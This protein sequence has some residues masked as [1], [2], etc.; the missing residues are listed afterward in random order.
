MI[1]DAPERR[2]E[3]LQLLCWSNFPIQSADKTYSVINMIT[4]CRT[5]LYWDSTSSSSYKYP[6]RATEKG[7]QSQRAKSR[8]LGFLLFSSLGFLFFF[9]FYV[10]EGEGYVERDTDVC[11]SSLPLYQVIKVIFFFCSLFLCALF[12]FSFCFLFFFSFISVGCWWHASDFQ[13]ISITNLGGC[14]RYFMEMFSSSRRITSCLC[15]T[16]WYNANR[17]LRS[18]LWFMRSTPPKQGRKC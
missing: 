16:W 17:G 3:D 10:S 5:E 8:V 11:F 2:L 18:I 4:S 6:C 13:R 15:E 12:Y 9:N 7:T 14:Q 1:Q